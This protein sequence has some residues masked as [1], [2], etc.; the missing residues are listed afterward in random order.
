MVLMHKLLLKPLLK[1]ANSSKIP[2]V[3]PLSPDTAFIKEMQSNF[4][5]Y[6]GLYHDQTLIPFKAV[7][8]FKDG[9]HLTVGLDFVRT[10]VD[11]GTA[12][13]LVGKNKAHH[14]SMLL[15]IQW[16]CRLA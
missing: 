7:H 6:L 5:V 13:D 9:V 8:G 2:V 10:S 11:H 1:W 12:K 3:G 15:A 14:E 16:A 4:A